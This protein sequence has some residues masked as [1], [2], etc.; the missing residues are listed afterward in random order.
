MPEKQNSVSYIS[1]KTL[2]TSLQ[3]FN[4]IAEGIIPQAKDTFHQQCTQLSF[5][6]NKQWTQ[7]WVSLKFL[8]S[9]EHK[10]GSHLTSN[11]HNWGCHFTSIVATIEVL[12]FFFPQVPA[13]T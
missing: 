5:P 10:C 11:E 6:F 4:T 9:N 12:I 13:D 8:T 2:L 7:V 3:N 1:G